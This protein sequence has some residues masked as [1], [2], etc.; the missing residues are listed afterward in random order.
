MVNNNYIKAYK[1][2]ENSV[3]SVKSSYEVIRQLMFQ[4]SN[5]LEKVIIDI[6]E[7]DVLETN[8]NNSKKNA[9]KKSRNMS[10]CL[11]II[12]GLQTCLDFDKSPEIAGNLFQLYEFSR[13]QVI[14]GFTKKDATGVKQ[15][16]EV[17]REIL[18][19]WQSISVEDRKI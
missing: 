3:I 9:L 4:L 7:S 12:F 10:R 13:Q 1:S 2:A 15:A 11:S 16:I 17:I 6:Q 14:K 8:H 19:G 5:S 18:G